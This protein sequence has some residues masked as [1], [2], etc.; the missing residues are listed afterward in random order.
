MTVCLS[1]TEEIKKLYEII[2]QIKSANLAQK[3]ELQKLID[4]LRKKLKEFQEDNLEEIQALK[5]KMSKL[6]QADISTL[7]NYYEN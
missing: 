5:E 3:K 1:K 7:E 4:G 2:S 6:H